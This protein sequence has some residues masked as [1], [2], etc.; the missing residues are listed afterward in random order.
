MRKFLLNILFLA[1]AACVV[2]SAPGGRCPGCTKIGALASRDDGAVAGVGGVPED[3]VHADASMIEYAY[4]REVLPDSEG[5]AGGV[6]SD[7]TAIEYGR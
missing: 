2:Q 6:H 1:V 5:G 7:A 4:A 3:G